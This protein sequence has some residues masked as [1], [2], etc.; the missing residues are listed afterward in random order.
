MFRRLVRPRH[1]LPRWNLLQVPGCTVCR[2]GIATYKKPFFENEPSP[3]YAKGSIERRGITKAL[4]RLKAELPIQ[5]PLMI[6]GQIISGSFSEKQLNPSQHRQPL[7]E[8]APA[9]EAHVHQAINSALAAKSAWEDLPFEDRAAVFLRAADLVTGKYRYEIIA[10]TML[11]QGKNIHQAE[12]DAAAE[13]ADLFRFYVQCGMELLAQ[14]PTVN[15][16]GVW[17]RL[18]Y[19]P[20]EGF[21]YA[22]SPF[23]FTALGGNLV[24]GP[25]L[26]GNVVIWKPSLYALHASWL[27]YNILLEAGL[28]KDVVQFVP[29]DAEEISRILFDSPHF[30]GLN[31]TG[32]TQV[33]KSLLGNIGVATAEDKYL[34][35]PR[36]VGETGGKNFHVIHQS[37][38]IENAVN[39]TIR[40]AFEYQGQKC[41]ATSRV[42]VAESIWPQVKEGIVQKTKALKVGSPEN[43]ENFVNAVIHEDAFNRLADVIEKAKTDPALTLLAGGKTSKEEGYYIY[44]TVYQT[45]DPQHELM[46][47]ELFGPIC[48]IYVFP[49]D[50]WTETLKL[51][52]GTSKYALTG[53]VFGRDPLALREA[54]TALRHSAGNFY[55]NTKSTGAVVAQQPFGGSRGSGTNDKVGSVN[56]LLRFASIRAIK[57]DFVGAREITYAS[58]EV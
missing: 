50:K 15:P 37:A 18:E 14:Q 7:A 45:S 36:V 38:D 3:S 16:P 32:S 10:A 27:L 2:M 5:I 8:W 21:I 43:Y 41:S 11:G 6:G 58:N 28:P 53:S 52:D 44:P 35:Y 46:Q 30:A 20:L 34:S 33:F 56:V 1:F 31:F 12:I 54:E 24:A 19:R 57:E 23:N 25:A 55:I 42:Y 9:K 4:E 49:D 39:N 13:T 26:M 17:N 29:G 40:G 48:T 47:R 51:I 22:I